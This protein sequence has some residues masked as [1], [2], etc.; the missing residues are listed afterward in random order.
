MIDGAFECIMTEVWSIDPRL[1]VPRVE[2]LVD[3]LAILK[4]IEN[5]RA[6]RT[7]RFES[8]RRSSGVPQPKSPSGT[9]AANTHASAIARTFGDP[10]VLRDEGEDDQPT[11]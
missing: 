7:S 8:P 1:V 2:K 6:S 4:S 3:K 11:M 9:L 5:S 10:P